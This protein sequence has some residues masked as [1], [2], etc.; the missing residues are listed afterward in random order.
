MGIGVTVSVSTDLP[1]S[2]RTTS[3]AMVARIGTS[4]VVVVS[5][6]FATGCAV[7]I[8]RSIAVAVT[9][10]VFVSTIVGIAVSVGISTIIIH[11]STVDVAIF[12]ELVI[13]SIPP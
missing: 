12:T 9:G 5:S 1:V 7:D 13:V 6:T 4:V 8:S 10:T 11:K 3:L 2:S